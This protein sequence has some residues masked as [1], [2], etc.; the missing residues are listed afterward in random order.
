[1]ADAQNAPRRGLS[2]DTVYPIVLTRLPDAPAVVVGGGPVGERKV[3]GLLAVGAAVR[4]ISPDATPQLQAWVEAGRL[5]WERR[6]YQTGDL[7]GAGLVFAAANRREV[8][9][10][11]ARDAARLGLLCNVADRP[12]EGNFFLPAVYRGDDWVIAVSTAGKSPARARRLRDRLAEWL[13]GQLD[14]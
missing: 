8:N 4:L 1:M 9:A 6:G 3:A 11:V 5:R 12:E 10:Q 13:A 14:L 2:P 7:D